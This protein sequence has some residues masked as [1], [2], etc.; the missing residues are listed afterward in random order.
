MI[1]IA[2]I[3]LIIFISAVIIS[4]NNWVRDSEFNSCVNEGLSSVEC[5]AV[6]E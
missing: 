1:R 2:I 6:Y 3:F 4:S 5:L